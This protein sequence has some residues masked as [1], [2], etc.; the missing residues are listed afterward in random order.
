MVVQLQFLHAMRMISLLL[1]ALLL[2]AGSGGSP[3]L[4]PDTSTSFT[5][6]ASN[7][8]SEQRQPPIG[9]STPN[10]D[11]LQGLKKSGRIDAK[12]GQLIE[13]LEISNPSGPCVVVGAGVHHVIIRRSRIG[14]CGP[15]GGNTDYGV[16]ILED[17]TNITVQGN[18]IHDVA[19]GVKAHQSTNPL[20]VDRN[21]FYNIRGTDY[22]GQAVQFNAVSG[23]TAASKVTCNVSDASY[24][25]GAKS[26]E[27]H[28]SMFKASGTQSAPIE[29]AYNRVRGGTSKTGGGITV[30]D[31][32]GAWI[33]VHDNIVVRVANTGIGVAG[34]SNIKVENN[35]VENRGET[36]VSMTFVAYFVRALS[37]CSNI[38][39]RGNRGIARLWNW[40]ETEGAL[41]FAYRA[42]P[43][44]CSTVIEENN[45]FSD[46]SLA[47]AMFDEIPAACQ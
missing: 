35:R 46:T 26:Y 32:G 11:D 15:S 1:P 4:G 5:R 8:A 23:G 38:T 10:A 39:V 36:A 6:E 25:S 29:V 22:N 44:F 42:G 34:G 31:F 14:P 27:D 47:P 33:N 17:A 24:G 41:T 2:A 28:I 30:G 13:Q 45:Q 18:V 20:I 19:S 12:S 21:Y 16:F 40:N 37:A 3:A 7:E 43:E 9:T